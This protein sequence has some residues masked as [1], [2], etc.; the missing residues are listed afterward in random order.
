MLQLDWLIPIC[1]YVR[2]KIQP[3]GIKRAEL[4]DSL[5]EMLGQRTY[6]DIKSTRQ[7]PSDV[8]RCFV[9]GSY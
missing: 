5:V 3:K 9:S 2:Y 6:R 8:D 7:C 1:N 4:K